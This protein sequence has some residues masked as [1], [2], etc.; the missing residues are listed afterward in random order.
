[1]MNDL[2][3]L[4]SAFAHS[5]CDRIQEQLTGYRPTMKGLDPEQVA[6]QV[7]NDCGFRFHRLPLEAR[8]A[9]VRWVMVAQEG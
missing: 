8:Q 7:A 3:D 6:V 2:P 5:V 1:M 4:R 9:L